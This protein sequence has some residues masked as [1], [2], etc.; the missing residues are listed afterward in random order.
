MCSIYVIPSIQYR[1]KQY[2][3]CGWEIAYGYPRKCLTRSMTLTVG[4]GIQ[5]L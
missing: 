2:S 3:I 5:H 4:L 1:Q